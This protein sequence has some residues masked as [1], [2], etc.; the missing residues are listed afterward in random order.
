MHID[1]SQVPAAKNL[2]TP[3]ADTKEAAGNQVIG[4]VEKLQG[5]AWIVH[6]G[7]KTPAKVGAPLMQ[8]DSV[9]TAQ[10]A[11][12]SMVF[13]DRT[14]FVLKDKGLVG[15]DEFSYDPAT[16]TGKESFLVAQGG[17]SFVSGDIAKTQ[18][19]AARIATPVMTMGIRGTTVA[20]AVGE[21]GE[22]TV[23]LLPDPGSNFV[24]EVA[25]SALGGGGGSFTLNS[26]GS[27]IVGATA[28]GSWSVSA[29]AGA[30]VANIAPAPAPPPPTPPVLNSAP[31][32][33]GNPSGP[34]NSN[35]GS[36][37]ATTSSPE[38]VTLPPQP[39]NLPAPDPKPEPKSEPKPDPKPEPKSDPKPD[40]VHSNHDPIVTGTVSLTGTGT[41][42][43]SGTIS[44]ASLVSNAR[45]PDGDALTITSITASNGTAIISGSNVIYT[46]AS[47]GTLSFTYTV[48]D[49]NGGTASDSASIPIVAGGAPLPTTTGA[50]NLDGGAGASAYET[51]VANFTAG[52]TI[53]DSGGVGVDTLTVTDAGTLDL[54]VG[55]VAGIEVLDLAAGGNTVIL[56]G[57]ADPQQFTTI[58][59][60]AGTDVIQQVNGGGTF[61]LT[62]IVLNSVESIA[63]GTGTSSVTFDET[64]AA[65]VTVLVDG[66]TGDGDSV[67]FYQTVAGTLDISGK[68]I[69]NFEGIILDG[70]TSTGDVVLT[71]GSQLATFIGGSGNDTFTGGSGA[72][73]FLG[74]LGDDVIHGASNDALMD[75]GGGTGDVLSI[76]TVNFDD[77]LGNN[78][79]IVNVETIN[80]T[81]ASSAGQWF[82]L[83]DQTDGFTINVT[84]SANVTLQGSQG[85]DVINGGSAGEYLSGDGGNDTIAGNAGND[86]VIG[87]SGTDV[88]VFNNNAQDYTY[89][90]SG[91]TI[92][93]AAQSG[94][95]GTDKVDTVETLRF[96]NGDVAVTTNAGVAISAIDFSTVTGGITADASALTTAVTLT[97]SNG[98]DTFTGGSGADSFLTGLGNDVIYATH[99]DPLINGGGGTDT[100]VVST[101]NFEDNVDDNHLQGIEV[102]NFTNASVAGQW[103]KLDNQSE[104]IT[105]NVTSTQNAT[106]LG[107]SGDDVI[108]GGNAGEYLWGY[109]GNDTITGGQGNDSIVGDAGTDVAVFSGNM[110][111]YAISDSAG[112]LTVAAQSGT[113]GTDTLD[114]VETLRFAD[115]DLTYAGGTLTATASAESLIVGSGLTKVDLGNGN[116]SLT[117]TN[118]VIVAGLSVVGGS[119]DD[120]L[121][122]SDTASLVA[123]QM[124]TLSGIETLTLASTNGATQSI[125]LGGEG[126][127]A[128]LNVV[129]GAAATGTI[130][131]YGNNRTTNLTLT[132][133]NGN[134]E[135]S[136]GSGNDTLAGGAGA[137]SFSAGSGSNVITGG[138]GT[139]TA[140]YATTGAAITATVSGSSAT[141]VHSGGTDSLSGVEVLVGGTYGDTVTTD[142]S[143]AGSF[144]GGGGADS[145]TL[146]ASPTANLTVDNSS[147]SGSLVLNVSGR[148][149]ESMLRDITWSGSDIVM[150]MDG[151]GQVT[152]VANAMN[153]LVDIADGKT[154]HVVGEGGATTAATDYMVVGTASDS[155]LTGNTGDD[156]LV[157]HSGNTSLIGGGGTD[158]AD[159]RHA[160]AAVV[161][162]MSGGTVA[163]IGG[164][165]TVGLSSSLTEIVGGDYADTLT[166]GTGTWML[167]GGDGNNTLDGSAGTTTINYRD[168][169]SGVT[170]NLNGGS[171]THGAYT[172]TLSGISGVRGSDFDDLIIGKAGSHYLDGGFGTDTVSYINSGI[173]I[174]ATLSGTTATVVHSGGTD[175]VVNAEVLVGSSNADTFTGGTGNDSFVGGSGADTYTGGAGNDA[176]VITDPSDSVDGAR[177]VI[178][179]FTT[180]ADH[181][182]L[183]LTG[184]HVD[185]SGFEVVA[186][187]NGGQTSLTGGS[188]RTGGVIGDGFYSTFDDALYIYKGNSDSGIATDGGYVVG[189]AST[190]NAADLNFKITGTAGNDTL[191][192]GAGN[193][194]LIGGDGTNTLTGGAGSDVFA[195]DSSATATA[196]VTDFNT[197]ADSVS[198]S[199]ASF[200][201]GSSGT[202][203]AADYAEGTT[204]IT[205]AAQNFGTGDGIVAIDDGSGNVE[206][207]HTT[208]MAAADNTNSH[209]VGTLNGVN[210]SALDNTNFHLAI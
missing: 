86:T 32:G 80:I 48:S 97:G 194:S 116:D 10:G 11:Q 25:V 95:D 162:D 104:G 202:L 98:A 192:G 76:D 159:F 77:G 29:N 140:S 50:D 75:G 141:V 178:T 155:T 45:D 64:S 71:G 3:I 121:V 138:S 126:D 176:F 110:S 16:K 91:T 59:G 19:D 1:P 94:T 134:D 113:D 44:I 133:G 128:G 154:L 57:G 189:S 201:L 8:G 166:G 102:V 203:A 18:P 179:D 15:L 147:G 160:S 145:V 167:T 99:S 168:Q 37:P 135:L 82:K 209:L 165:T 197:A 72:D 181:I 148:S 122:I 38:P 193:D 170:V 42:G 190:I 191:V 43:A 84:S 6:N 93:L 198:L 205:G 58:N 39:V 78:G 67:T 114:G 4:K 131:I 196:V 171:A 2:A 149:A 187:Y 144:S 83:D 70:S 137:D 28:G 88:A 153:T 69:T 152:N 207:W 41:V 12:I 14:T 63:T 182:D 173:G 30:A 66:A 106:V 60:G 142:G 204:T 105:I 68:T 169:T 92:T 5:D 40:P 124:A 157:W 186:S 127:S 62:G 23:A 7:Q 208:D 54:S 130:S 34:T 65:G 177:D 61:D 123:T 109:S 161:A 119:G 55:T 87:G 108:N 183:S 49:G 46:P 51:A 52:D 107:G 85:S 200:S 74:G 156:I 27:G 33:T 175:T 174:E 96:A 26:A 22:T 185:V 9:E 112:V 120:Q 163:V 125:T 164:S 172:D 180:G 143:V 150:T 21:G 24:G 81:N 115:G 206:V 100:L 195:L 36:E 158:I 210:T 151:G 111:N 129:S 53:S 73:S 17:F 199:N 117:T 89:T 56:G 146:T 132:G 184:S 90:L 188:A 101:T 136:S 35:N 79:Q 31:T 20:G 139:D 47:T 13:A 118:A 103:F